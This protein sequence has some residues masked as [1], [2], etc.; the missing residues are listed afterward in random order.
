MIMTDPIRVPAN[1]ELEDT[2][3]GTFTA[4]QVIVLLIIGASLYGLLALTRPFVP[5]VAFLIFALPV[6]VTAIALVVIR[7]DG[8]TLDR[9]LVAAIRQRLAPRRRVA[10]ADTIDTVPTWLS[11]RAHGAPESSSAPVE[12]PAH[13]V[14]E[15]GVIDLGEGGRAMIA[16]A[17]TVNFAL[18][19]PAEQHALVAC[20][21]RYLHSLTA[22]VQILIRAERLDLSQPIADLHNAAAQLPHPALEHAALEHADYLTELGQHSDLLRRQVLIVLREPLTTAVAAVPLE[23]L[24]PRRAAASGAASEETLRTVH[25]R[26]LRRLTEA[27]QLLAPAG[28]S[29]TPLDAGQVTAV[30]ASACSPESLLPPSAGLAGADEVITLTAPDDWDPQAWDTEGWG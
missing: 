19:T 14:S 1:V 15:A 21:A 3:I 26:L 29:L 13:G 20:L 18:R 7:R 10:V 6:M 30:L 23:Q 8:L 25:A 12:L 4:R 2:I 28:I 16:V 5:V 27:S 9:L 24:R 17:S 22:P 11:E